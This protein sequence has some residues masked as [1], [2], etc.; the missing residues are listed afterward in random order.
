MFGITLKGK[1]SAL[2][3]RVETK[4]EDIL[5]TIERKSGHKQDTVMRRTDYKWTVKVA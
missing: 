3:I 4:V 1:K 2:W 5:T